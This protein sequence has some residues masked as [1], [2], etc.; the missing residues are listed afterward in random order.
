MRKASSSL[1]PLKREN[2]QRRGNRQLGRP[3]YPV[4]VSTSPPPPSF[5][6]PCMPP[7]C[8]TVTLPNGD[9]II[10]V[11]GR[12]I[13]RTRHQFHLFQK[14]VL[15][16][17]MAPPRTTVTLP[18][19]DQIIL[20]GGRPSVRVLVQLLG[21]RGYS[22][23]VRLFPFNDLSLVPATDRPYS[24][25]FRDALL[26]VHAPAVAPVVSRRTPSRR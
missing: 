4:E 12:P 15:H 25:F 18:N 24:F 3:N 9:R 7:P 22:V 11:G 17:R 20:V 1:L 6:R 10:L 8:T 26:T 14:L 21:S 16:P 13:T 19:G 2:N 23:E 5:L